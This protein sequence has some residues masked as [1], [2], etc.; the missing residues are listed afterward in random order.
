MRRCR[1]SEAV[2]MAFQYR[3]FLWFSQE[4]QGPD[5]VVDWCL[6]A[7]VGV[8]DLIMGVMRIVKREWV[9]AARVEE[10]DGDKVFYPRSDY[11]GV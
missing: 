7:S 3:V 8:D 6:P 5:V 11:G 9:Y 4:S 1:E 10:D 2:P